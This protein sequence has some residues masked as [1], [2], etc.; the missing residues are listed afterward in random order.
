MLL[1]MDGV[2]ND[3]GDSVDNTKDKTLEKCLLVSTC[4]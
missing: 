1:Y 2:I 4:Y 3:F